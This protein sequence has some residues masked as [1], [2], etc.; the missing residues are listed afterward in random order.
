MRKFRTAIITG[1]SVLTFVGICAGIAYFQG[2]DGIGVPKETKTPRLLTDE[3]K[4]RY[5][6]LEN[7]MNG[8]VLDTMILEQLQEQRDKLAAKRN[9]SELD[10]EMIKSYDAYIA[11]YTQKLSENPSFDDVKARIDDLLYE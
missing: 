2:K 9:P 6:E 3:E 8:I 4:R 7:E 5:E 10:T 1:I 11:E